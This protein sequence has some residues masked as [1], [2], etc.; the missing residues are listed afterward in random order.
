MHYIYIGMMIMLGVYLA[1]IVL[2]F[3][4]G[5]LEAVISPFIKRR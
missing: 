3:S 2:A 1:P 5:I 4:V